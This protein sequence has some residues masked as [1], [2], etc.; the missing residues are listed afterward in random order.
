M[1]MNAIDV[2]VV[3]NVIH[4][5]HLIHYIVT[6]GNSSHYSPFDSLVCDPQYNTN[7]IAITLNVSALL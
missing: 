6:K 5:F 7:R 4:T 3:P 1:A 2:N